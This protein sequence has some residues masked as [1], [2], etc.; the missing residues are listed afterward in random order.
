MS[1]E[2]SGN[3]SIDALRDEFGR[4]IDS[5]TR[6]LSIE[7]RQQTE[8][9][10]E[11]LDMIANAVIAGILIVIGSLIVLTPIVYEKLEVF[12]R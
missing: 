7:L 8:I 11:K 1:L 12:V 3:N 2:S 5:Q 4:R 10:E 9:L 6:K